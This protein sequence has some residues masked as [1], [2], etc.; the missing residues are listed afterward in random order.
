MSCS[1]DFSSVQDLRVDTEGDGQGAQGA[2]RHRGARRCQPGFVRL[3]TLIAF[4]EALQMPCTLNTVAGSK[5]ESH[6]EKILQ[7]ET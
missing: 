7:R 1:G 3:D 2:G 5:Q 6:Q 4:E